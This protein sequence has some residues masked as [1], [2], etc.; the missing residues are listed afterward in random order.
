MVSPFPENIIDSQ[1]CE[2]GEV[3]NT[4]HF[5]LHCN[6]FV[7]LRHGLL[8]RVLIFCQPTVNVFLYGSTGLSDDQNAEIMSAVQHYYILKSKR[9]CLG[10]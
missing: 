4:S 1:V 9:L 2:C 8:N 10:D 7:Q 3:E 5:F 6:D